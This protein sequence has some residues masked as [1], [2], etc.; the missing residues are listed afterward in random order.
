[1]FTFIVIQIASDVNNES[2]SQVALALLIQIF[3]LNCSYS[4]IAICEKPL[5]C[6][7][8]FLL[9]CL[10][11]LIC[12][13]CF[14]HVYVG[15]KQPCIL[16]ILYCVKRKKIHAQINRVTKTCLRQCFLTSVINM[17]LKRQAPLV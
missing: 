13:S 15:N 10:N 7:N 3:K 4:T 17:N 2:L 14:I 11:L 9:L 8:S 5:A 12:L 6:K 16:C 1:M